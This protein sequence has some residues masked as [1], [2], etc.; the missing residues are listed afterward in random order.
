MSE[1]RHYARVDFIEQATL[2]CNGTT[3]NVTLVDI[4]L[5]GALLQCSA[6]ITVEPDIDCTISLQLEGS[7]IILQ[8]IAHAAH[9]HQDTIG[10]QFTSMD[11]GSMSHLRRLL[12]LNT[13]NPDEIDRELS[14]MVR[15]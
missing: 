7:D 3:Y 11:S 2:C 1:K 12:E 13:G 9:L 15:H 8:F 14:Y 5:K 4:S 10:F 6:P